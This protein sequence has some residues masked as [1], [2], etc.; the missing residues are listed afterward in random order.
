MSSQRRLSTSSSAS[1][2]ERRGVA[3]ELVGD[4][5]GALAPQGRERGRVAAAVVVAAVVPHL[6]GDRLGD[7]RLGVVVALGGEQ[8]AQ[9]R[10]RRREPQQGAVRV[11]QH[12]PRRRPARRGEGTGRVR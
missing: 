12:D 4:H 10:S 2:V 9:P 11:E 8:R 3:A 1:R 5:A 6:G 7:P